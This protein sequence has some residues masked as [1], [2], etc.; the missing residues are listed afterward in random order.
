[1]L[2]S[3]LVLA[4]N[5]CNTAAKKTIMSFKRW[6]ARLFPTFRC[7]R[8]HHVYRRL[9][10]PALTL[11]LGMNVL[12]GSIP[13]NRRWQARATFRLTLEEGGVFTSCEIRTIHQVTSCCK[14]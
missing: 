7:F 12:A 13:A 1:M 11:R 5:S 14:N 8:C 2:C 9:P 6:S 3:F 4:K 10:L